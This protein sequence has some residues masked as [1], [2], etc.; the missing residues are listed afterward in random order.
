[1]QELLLK[2]LLAVIIIST[3]VS[4]QEVLGTEQDQSKKE[5][6]VARKSGEFIWTPSNKGEIK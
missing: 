6:P 5:I 1:M 2:T 3:V 4:I